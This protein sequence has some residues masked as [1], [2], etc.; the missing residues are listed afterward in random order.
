MTKTADP[1][2][3][4]DSGPVDYTVVIAN[5]S[6]AD[7][8]TVDRL[9]DSVYGDLIAGPNRASCTYGGEAVQLPFTLPIGQSMTCTFRVIVTETV[10]DTVTGSGTDDEGNRVIDADNAVVTVGITPPSLPQPEPPVVGPAGDPE[11]ALTI[12]KTAPPT[13]FVGA[14]VSAFVNDIRVS[15]DGPDPAPN[16]TLDDPGP[17]SSRFLRILQQ[18]SQGSCA[19]RD[20][21]R[22]L[23]CE[24]GT[25]PA[26][27][28][29]GVVVLVGVRGSAGTTVRNTATAACSATGPTE[30][31]AVAGATTRLLAG[32]PA[33]CAAVTV[34][35][36]ALVFDGG[37]HALRI[38][39]RRAGAAV[40]GAR[41]LLLGPGVVRTVRTGASGQVTTTVRPSRSGVLR[42][43]LLGEPRCPSQQV[44]IAP[45][46]TG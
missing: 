32:A 3:V 6:T 34:S 41:L 9:V 16:V 22:N 24:F 36:S 40:A 45:G 11:V 39:V 25:L 4:Q 29:V 30:C 19:I 17:G 35:P 8:L 33:T 43:R 5:T 23:H 2:Y 7:A 18:P 46:V 28:L 37:Q 14:G 1:T 31:V 12:T 15:N 27:N 20:Q 13:A 26:H 44:P 21:G 10:T 38:G 42:V